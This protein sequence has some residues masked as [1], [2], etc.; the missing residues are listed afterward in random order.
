MASGPIYILLMKALASG[1]IID[2]TLL[3]LTACPQT[4]LVPMS[5][6]HT[7]STVSGTAADSNT[8]G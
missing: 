2:E 8:S 7:R 1:D 3:L 6:N 5:K 4:S